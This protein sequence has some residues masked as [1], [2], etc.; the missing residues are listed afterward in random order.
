M[1]ATCIPSHTTKK[2]ILLH[3]TLFRNGFSVQFDTL[4]EL[5][6]FYKEHNKTPRKAA[7]HITA[8]LW[9]SFLLPFQILVCSRP[10]SGDCDGTEIFTMIAEAE[11]GLCAIGLTTTLIILDACPSN[12]NAIEQHF[13]DGLGSTGMKI[14]FTFDPTHIYKR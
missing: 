6:G 4:D 11:A 1:F 14:T 2:T 13:A 3:S 9:S 10:T 8:I 7:T 12:R 5:C